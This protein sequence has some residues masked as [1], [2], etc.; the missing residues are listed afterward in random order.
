[1]KLL[2]RYM[3][4]LGPRTVIAEVADTNTAWAIQSAHMAMGGEATLCEEMPR[5]SLATHLEKHRR[6]IKLVPSN[7]T[8]MPLKRPKA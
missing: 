7:T 8:V 2:L 3:T 5:L 1:M 4:L 6:R